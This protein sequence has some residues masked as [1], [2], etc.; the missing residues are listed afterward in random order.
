MDELKAV[1]GWL[2]ESEKSGKIKPLTVLIGGWAVYSYN[3]WYQSIDID[4]VT[5]KDIKESLM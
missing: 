4:L 1:G 5:N 2:D 3:P